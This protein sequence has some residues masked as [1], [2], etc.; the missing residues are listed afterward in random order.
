[1]LLIANQMSAKDIKK[2]LI[3]VDMNPLMIPSTFKNVDEVPKLGSGKTDFSTSR[4]VAL[5]EL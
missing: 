1:V 3:N 5:G 2:A 4:K